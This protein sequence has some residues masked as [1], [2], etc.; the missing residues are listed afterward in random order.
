MEKFTEPSEDREYPYFLGTEE[1]T[2]KGN[3]SA[4]NGL[5]KL[6]KRHEQIETELDILNQVKNNSSVFDVDDEITIRQ[7][8]LANLEL[9]M[10]KYGKTI[11]GGKNN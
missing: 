5:E 9:E 2:E 7:T 8:E 6:E 11:V 10:N 1:D 3:E 4:T